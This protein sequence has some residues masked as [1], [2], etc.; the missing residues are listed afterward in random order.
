MYKNGFLLTN[1]ESNH[2]IFRYVSKLSNVLPW[3]TIWLPR[4]ISAYGSWI[5]VSSYFLNKQGC[6]IVT[7]MSHSSRI[8]L[9]LFPPFAVK[10]KFIMPLTHSLWLLSLKSWMET[11]IEILVFWVLVD[12]SCSCN[13]TV[14]SPD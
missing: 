12:T 4:T 1:R 11:F 5:T 6:T 13:V 14:L 10:L 8:P 7:P 9:L 3:Q 2:A